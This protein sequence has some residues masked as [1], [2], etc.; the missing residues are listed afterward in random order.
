MLKAISMNRSFTSPSLS[1]LA[2]VSLRAV[3]SLLAAVSLVLVTVTV[4]ADQAAHAA[5]TKDTVRVA[6]YNVFLNN[7]KQWKSRLSK[8]KATIKRANVDIL[9]I[10]EVTTGP[11]G[12]LPGRYIDDISNRV[13]S[14]LGFAVAGSPML[15]TYPVSADLASQKSA[16]FSAQ[17]SVLDTHILYKTAKFDLVSSGYFSSTAVAKQ[18]SLWKGKTLDRWIS[19]AKLKHKKSG[20]VVLVV[21]LHLPPE[22][23]GVSSSRSEKLRKAITAGTIRWV[24]ANRKGTN[25]QIILGDLNSTDG[26]TPKG[27]PFLLRKAGYRDAVKATTAKNANYRTSHGGKM[28][29]KPISSSSPDNRID[30]IFHRGFVNKAV[31]YETQIVLKGKKFNPKFQGSD[32]NLVSATLRLK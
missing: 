8:H 16:T 30:Y 25:Q 1:P 5:R 15:N 11:N 24:A 20:R 12:S 21:N 22:D 13:T 31:R 9:G 26:R 4:P 7:A 19:W 32:H 27:S 23:L 17:K 14:P 29:S 10:Q 6:S 28:T 2:A 3:I 18:A